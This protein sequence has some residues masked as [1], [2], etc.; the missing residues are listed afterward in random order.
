[1]KIDQLLIVLV[2]WSLITGIVLRRKC[3]SHF[4]TEHP[5]EW[6]TIERSDE[7]LWVLLL[8]Y[9]WAEFRRSSITFFLYR[10]C[11]RGG[12]CRDCVWAGCVLMAADLVLLASALAL[13]VRIKL[14]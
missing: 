9:P 8:N 4:L 10:T 1:M 12:P 2:G 6:D 3:D 14:F 11:L 5:T 13:M 7:H